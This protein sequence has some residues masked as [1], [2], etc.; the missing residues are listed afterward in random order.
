MATTALSSLRP[1]EGLRGL[2]QLTGREV[3]K[4][5]VMVGFFGIFY[6]A[7]LAHGLFWE[8]DPYWT[9]W[10]TKTFLITTVFCLTTAFFGIGLAQGLVATAVHTVVLEVYYQWLSP[11]GLPREPQWL[12]F[13]HLWITGVPVHY[14]AIFAGYL[15]ALWLWRRRSA[16]TTAWQASP[17]RLG[18]FALVATVLVLAL[19][20]IITQGLILR[21]NPGLTFF[22]VRALISVAFFFALGAYVGL[23][24]TGVVVGSVLLALV[25]TTYSMYLGPTGLPWGPIKYPGYEALWL[26]SFPG[27]LIA[28]LI[29]IWVAARLTGLD[30][31]R[32]EAAATAERPAG[33]P[34]QPTRRVA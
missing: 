8:N 33:A 7:S 15:T 12:S 20:A 27:Q 17:R 34:Q 22:V 26:R 25:W 6:D 18:V 21:E 19:D 3:A 29:G 16:V 14:A 10:I 13:D 4:F 1:P 31:P 24:L 2:N 30:H 23:D 28:M 5:G 32:V 11:I 9:Y